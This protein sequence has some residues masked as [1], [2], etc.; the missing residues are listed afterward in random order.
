MILN[1]NSL[2]LNKLYEMKYKTFSKFDSINK[3]RNKDTYI[4]NVD[5]YILHT[6][7]EISEVFTDE[8]EREELI[9]VLLYLGTIYSFILKTMETKY[10]I[11][12]NDYHKIE[13]EET[14]KSKEKY[15]FND[16]FM[17]LMEIRR[18]FPERKW[19]KNDTVSGRDHKKRL[20]ESKKIIEESMS[21]VAGVILDKC[22][23]ENEFNKLVSKKHNKLH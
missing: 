7:E 14:T 23:D 11:Y 22:I 19:H 10:D 4:H 6:L 13:L 20:K 2:N 9:D 15:L 3:F 21:I 1:N 17:N 16:V 5:K 8:D 18:K 12:I